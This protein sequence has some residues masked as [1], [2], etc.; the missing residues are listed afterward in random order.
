MSNPFSD[1]YWQKEFAITQA[2]VKRISDYIRETGI[3]Q[4]SNTLIHRIVRGR[5]RF[6]SDTSAPAISLEKVGKKVRM[7]DPVGNWHPGDMVIVARRHDT[8]N[9]FEA[10]L[11]EVVRIVRVEEEERV[12]IQLDGIDQ[13]ATYLK[14]PP[15]SPAAR[16]WRA[17]VEEALQQQSR[18]GDPDAD[19]NTILLKYGERISG[20]LLDALRTQ[21]S[22]IYLDGRWY[23]R[24]LAVLPTEAQLASLAW[25]MLAFAASQPTADLVTLV[26]P[27]LTNGAAG[28]FGLYL[29][30]QQHPEIF[31]NADPGLRPRWRLVG[32]PPGA[33]VARPAAYDP[34][35]HAVL[36]MPGEPLPPKLVS[37]LW[38]LG[39]LRAVTS[40]SF[41][42]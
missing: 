36:C 10:R 29:A 17:T 19:A 9:F 16:R 5:M 18:R 31:E 41:V 4:D 39:L 37:R 15:G 8:G 38:Q 23:L 11:G 25:A 22:F 20:Q 33:G 40:E 26:Q 24:E 7:W 2:D 32:P 13:P 28:L 12:V 3:A 27:P 34:K 42:V 21:E 14:A 30:L 35:T 6:G 1:K